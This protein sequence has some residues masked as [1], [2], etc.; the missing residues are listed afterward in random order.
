MQ[1][2]ESYSLSPGMNRMQIFDSKPVLQ[3]VGF[4]PLLY[5]PVFFLV[6]LKLALILLVLWLIP[7]LIIEFMHVPSCGDDF[8]NYAST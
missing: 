8:V 3:K 2:I 5:N 4:D 1:Q 6:Q 7:G